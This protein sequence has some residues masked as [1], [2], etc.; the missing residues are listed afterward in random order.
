MGKAPDVPERQLPWPPTKVYEY[1]D[2][3]GELIFAVLRFTY[4][5]GDK[6][7]RQGVPDAS[8]CSGPT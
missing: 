1:T 8:K 6:T 2:E 7:F 4:P 5:E 3:G